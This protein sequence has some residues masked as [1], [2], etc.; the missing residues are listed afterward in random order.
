MAMQVLL[1]RMTK[2]MTTGTDL[3]DYE[4]NHV[5]R[6]LT[7]VARKQRMMHISKRNKVRPPFS[8]VTHCHRQA[9]WNWSAWALAVPL[10]QPSVGLRIGKGSEKG[11]SK[12]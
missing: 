4:D 1:Q 5:A 2:I 11:V 8:S 9:P 6:S 10:S 3:F 7:S 12:H